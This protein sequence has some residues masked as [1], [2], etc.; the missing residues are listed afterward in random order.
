MS[1]DVQSVTEEAIVC[2][3]RGKF[4]IVVVGSCFVDMLWYIPRLPKRGETIHATKFQMDFGGKAANQCCMASKLGAKVAMVAMVGKDKFGDDTIQNFKDLG[5]NTDHILQTDDAATGV[6]SINVDSEG[7]P[8]FISMAG[9]NRLLTIDQVQPALNKLQG[10]HVLVCDKGIPLN[11]SAQVLKHG[12][13][14][15]AKTIFNPSPRIEQMEPEMY[16]SISLMVLNGDEGEGLTGIPVNDITSA[17][18]V[19]M[20][21]HKRGT[22]AVVLTLGKHGAVCSQEGC[23]MFHVK[24]RQVQAVDTTGAGDC[25]VGC[26]AFYLANYPHLSFPEMVARAVDIATTAVTSGGVQSSYPSHKDLSQALFDDI[27]VYSLD[28]SIV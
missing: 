9:S 20:E 27:E 1:G 2:S 16:R 18:T 8:G 17:K 19:I 5:V 13:Q 25:L 28:K 12:K 7:K 23:P 6:T 3:E 11:T 22:A 26:L 21:I 10:F 15:G 4:E 14:L 24:T